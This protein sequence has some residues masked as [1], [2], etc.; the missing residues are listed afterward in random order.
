MCTRQTD[1]NNVH[2]QID[3]LSIQRLDCFLRVT[4]IWRE[5]RVSEAEVRGH[6]H[7]SAATFELDEAEAGGLARD[8][9]VADSTLVCKG[10]AKREL[11]VIIARRE[12]SVIIARNFSFFPPSLPPV[13]PL[14]HTH[15][16]THTHHTTHIHTFEEF[17]EVFLGRARQQAA[18]VHFRHAVGPLLFAVVRV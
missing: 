11:S 1:F 17:F 13:P 7:E 10:G 14:T 12:V 2:K 3:S 15:T 4:L 16:H 8:P 9:D 6:P 18:D 5:Q